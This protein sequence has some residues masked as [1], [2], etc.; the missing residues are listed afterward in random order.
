MLVNANITVWDSF[1]TE[2]DNIG[3]FVVNHK[4]NLVQLARTSGVDPL[5]LGREIHQLYCANYGVEDPKDYIERGFV[6]VREGSGTTPDTLISVWS[7]KESN[8]VTTYN[9]KIWEA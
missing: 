4:H 3:T 9:C 1:T 8:T 2:T 6:F 7:H 5:V